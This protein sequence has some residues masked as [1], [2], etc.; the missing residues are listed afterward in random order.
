MN[1][2]GYDL[3]S[4]KF[5]LLLSGYVGGL[6]GLLIGVIIER[7]AVP[8][9]NQVLVY[10]AD[11]P[12]ALSAI[13]TLGLVVLTAVYTHRT[14]QLV[15]TQ[16]RAREHQRIESWYGKMMTTVRRLERNWRFLLRHRAPKG[17]VHLSE[18]ES[19]YQDVKE[20]T[21]QL[22]AHV[23]GR[24]DGIDPDLVESADQFI[25]EWEQLSASDDPIFGHEHYRLSHLRALRVQIQNHS[26]L[27]G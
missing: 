16:Y 12:A 14:R 27:Y 25:E 19:I 22:D 15:E 11:N 6:G 17:I 21:D 26:D 13:G 8:E 4:H 7:G 20:L 24:P 9:V 18:N 5:H 10:L 1:A 3:S 2:D 23:A